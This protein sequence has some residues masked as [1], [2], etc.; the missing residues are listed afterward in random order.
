MR[1]TLDRP[2][3]GYSVETQ[4]QDNGAWMVQRSFLPTITLTRYW[5]IMFEACDEPFS[6]KRRQEA[7]EFAQTFLNNV[8][9]REF[10]VVPSGYSQRD[11][12]VIWK[13]GQWL[14]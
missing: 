7:K 10:Q 13:N 11:G 3:Y 14:I 1:I 9:L 8:R 5:G 4:N 6:L 12:V 2:A